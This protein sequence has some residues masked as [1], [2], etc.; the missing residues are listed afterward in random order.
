MLKLKSSWLLVVIPLASYGCSDRN[1]ALRTPGSGGSPSVVSK[2]KSKVT[3]KI[4]RT[5]LPIVAP[6]PDTYDVLDVRNIKKPKRF[7]VKPPKG[8]PNVV[9]VLIDD[10]GIGSTEV[11]GGP[12]S[13]PT[14]DKLA[15]NG[16]RYNRF[17]TTALY[18]P[19][20]AALK[21]GRNHHSVNMG[22][23][24]E[25]AT[26]VPGYTGQIPS[27]AASIGEI[28]KLNGY[29]TAAFGKWH[30]TAAWETGV[31]G[32]FDRWPTNQGFEHFYG[33]IGAETDQWHPSV[34]EG[35]KKISPP[36]TKDYHFTTDMTDHAIAWVRA[37]QSMSP[38]T[39]FFMYY[40]P[41]AAHAP[42]HAPKEWI[43]KYKGRF[44]GGW[45]EL[46]TQTLARQKQLG[47]VPQNTK[48]APR[49]E[50]VQPWDSFSK[51][52]RRLMARQAEVFA[53]FVSHTD[54]QI[55]RLV[56]AID[57]LGALDDTVLIFI[58]GDNG[59]SAE[60]GPIGSVNEAAVVN[61][62]EEKFSDLLPQ[63]D[64]W[65]GPTT[66]PHMAFGWAVAFDAPFAW[67]KQIASD[68]GGTRNG[69]VI[70]WPKGIK[71]KGELRQQFTHVIDV[72]PTILE[73]AKIPEPKMVNG[74]KQKP[75]EG[76]SMAYTFD[77]ANA[78]EKHD[79]QYFEM[80]GNRAIYHDGW[81]ARTIHRMPW[82]PGEVAPLEQDVWDLYN[83]R[84]DFSLANNLATQN[85]KKLKELQGL[86]MKE[87]EKYHALPID[88]RQV[89][90][91]NAALAGRPDVMDGRKSLTL[92]GGA[93]S[94]MEN[95]FIN[96]KNRSSTVVAE[97]DA[98]K[99]A[100]GVI[101]TQGGSFGGWCL[102]MK[103]GKPVYTYNY[104]GRE[105]YTIRSRKALPAGKAKIEVRFEYEGGKEVG[106]G[107][108]VT[109]MV[110]GKEVARGRVD[111][112][113]PNYFAFDET[114][115]VGLDFQ[116]PVAT[117]IGH[118]P[119]ETKFS[120]DIHKV[121]ISVE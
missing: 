11:F 118:G 72:V 81:L 13:T 87:A 36:K 65:G 51:S 64:E 73:A 47:V 91:L 14:L 46:R 105:R 24:T 50:D 33:F 116:T 4:D 32:P 106:K 39:P 49:P 103:N 58:A 16:L 83:T 89:E 37:Q 45:D 98:N 67:T 99:K 43:D 22:A 7:E 97:I 78:P 53:G 113:H 75:I 30:E 3:G 42:H 96:T 20:R 10:L 40:A 110:N 109:L 12:I 23:I 19:T 26:S 1:A 114:A 63:I 62:L 28:L 76:T 95:A 9:V 70:H 88:D 68:F 69:M 48:L 85:P 41:G 102:Y 31:S 86:F 94:M 79:T 29:N 15:S 61:G 27:S 21:S 112:T 77:N 115:D 18:S 90:R 17:H 120:G 71:S 117:D 5:V 60:G 34:Y 6:E 101:I 80:F 92:Y 44:D 57:E 8:A 121:T 111:K 82:Q 84:D 52:E 56:N 55:G 74:V 2:I 25:M 38:D 119:E 54:H 108:E 104:V 66:Y 93:P 59:T 35:T 107:G 100:T